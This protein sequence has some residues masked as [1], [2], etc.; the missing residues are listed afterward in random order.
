[1]RK[2]VLLIH[3]LSIFISTLIISGCGGSHQA[4]SVDLKNA[5]L[6]NPDILEKGTSSEQALYRYLNPNINPADYTK[7]LI[8]PVI[9]SK[10][11]ELTVG[12]LDNYQK[13]AHN[14]CVYLV[15]ELSDHLTIVTVAQPGTMRIQ[16]A[17]IDADSSKPIRNI[18]SYTPI[19][20]GAD[21]MKYA[22]TGKQ[23]AVGEITVEMKV[24]DALSG[25]LL[26]AAVDRRIGGKSPKDIV[27]V[28]QNADNAL[29][30]WAK[31]LTFVI[32]KGK[33]MQGCVNP[34]D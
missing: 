16:A 4:R 31:R 1:M 11:A 29:K 20:I 30:Y 9:I 23:T 7:V 21:L 33:G 6:I 25:Q 27:D 18:L 26:G 28:W 8:D 3:I 14:F 10:Q 15:E 34:H 5:L 19:G 12:E 2:P 22:A 17:I 32:C 24:T 13:L